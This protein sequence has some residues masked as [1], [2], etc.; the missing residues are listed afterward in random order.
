L[1]LSSNIGKALYPGKSPTMSKKKGLDRSLKQMINIWSSS[2]TL[3][4]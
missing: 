1:I 4:V 2:A 3:E